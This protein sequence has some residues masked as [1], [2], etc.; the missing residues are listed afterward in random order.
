MQR[1]IRIAAALFT[2]WSMTSTAWAELPRAETL[3]AD[4]GLSASEIAEVKAV[5][6]VTRSV[7]AAHDR[8]L[9][10]SFAFFAP[11]PPTEL[12][13][14]LRAGLLT[15]V[16]TNTISHGTLST[17]GSLDDL[18]ALALN[19]DGAKRARRYTSG[20]D[21]L[22]LSAD[23]RAA[24]AKLPATAP[25]ADVEA[26]LRASLLARY[27]AY[28]TK[29]LAG[30]APY[31]R[32]GGAARSAG[33]DLRV[34]L[35]SLSGLKK[36]APNAFTAMAGYPS[37]QPAGTEDRVTWVQLTAHGAPTIV[38]TQG[39]VIPDGDGFLA[40]QRQ[41]YVSEGFNAEQAVAGILPAQGGTIVIYMN[42]T[43]TDQVSGFGG[44][45]KRSIGSKL[46][47][48]ELQGI[49]TKVQKAKP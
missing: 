6:I 1:S 37:A 29:G 46:M 36:Y 42:H 3:L 20:D 11:I 43:S 19:P 4:L 16:D 12:V 2:F 41:F 32:K 5:H 48:S 24:F 27:Q 33:D 38:L 23:E 35:E 17:A 47:S 40:M 14:Q 10:T 25:V 18:K 22:N 28:H 44:S 7:T 15:K 49:F 13:K 30:I 31:A 26:Q 39:L 34:S 9:A 21:D 45:A 8:D